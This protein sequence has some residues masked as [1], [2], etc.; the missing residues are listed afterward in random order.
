MKITQI[1][2]LVAHDVAVVRVRTDDGAEGI[3]QTAPFMADITAAVLHRLV[4]DSFLGQNP[5]DV[6]ALVRECLRRRYKYTGTFLLRA[7][8]GVD[9]AIYDLLGNITGQPVYRLLGG[10]TRTEIP[11]YASRM[12]RHTS[13]E[14]EVGVLHA[15][16]AEG[17]KAAKIKISGRMNHDIDA[18]P[19]RTETLIALARR[20]MGD[21]F[22]LYADANGGCSV[23]G[24]VRV[25]HMLQDHNFA[26]FEEPCPFTD[27]ES[28]AQVAAALTIPIAGGEQD[29]LLPQFQRMIAQ[30]AVSIVQ[31]DVGYVGGITQAQQ[32]AQMALHAGLPFIPH[33]SNHAMQ[34]IFSLHL[35]ATLPQSASYYEYGYDPKGRSFTELYE[36]ALTVR[37]GT[38][39][40]SDRPGWGLTLCAVF[41]RQAESRLSTVDD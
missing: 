8:C 38:A 30:H 16:A 35:I 23:P 24:A 2:T 6:K 41:I 7:L 26:F 29:N 34:W 22:T 25:G 13:P 39:Y 15:A 17:F 27:I 3:G 37:E 11:L 33:S 28:T 10:A 14:E 12:A 36:P 19:G 31:A 4:A 40:L 18:A 20:E 21:D 9:T 32:V 1:E 5:W